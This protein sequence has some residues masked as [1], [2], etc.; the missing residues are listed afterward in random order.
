MADISESK[1]HIFV[2]IENFL[3]K[4][5]LSG[6]LLF[7]AAL[8][9]MALANSPWAESYFNLLHTSVGLAIGERT[10]TMNLGHWVNDGLMALFFLV[11]G[12]EIKRELMVGEL[13]SLQ[14]AAFPIA[15]AAGGMIVPV[16][17]YIAVNLQCGGQ[18]SGFGIPMATDIAFALGF[19][20]LLGDRVPLSL[21][22]F[23]T[24]LA[25][26][27]DLGAIIVIAV[28]YTGSLHL[29]ALGYAAIAL[30]ALIALNRFG[31]KKLWPY[32]ILGVALWLCV[33]E[34]GIHA[35]IAGVLLALTIPVRARI[36]SKK[37]L[38]ICHSEL[39]TFDETEIN[40]KDMVLTSEQQDSLEALEDAYEAVQNPL[41]RLEHFLHP[42]SAFFIM[43]LFALANA[44][45]QI[46]GVG[47]SFFSPVSLGVLAGL[48]LGKPLGIAGATIVLMIL[49]EPG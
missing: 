30:G 44:G 19:L 47:S 14:Q 17:F 36:D 11:I 5:A 25:V 7:G 16:I 12:L 43:P 39:T 18:P 15:G 20:L 33:E 22:V 42:I 48:V 41:V 21:K 37:F 26:F 4:E 35:T 46:S 49:C 3:R 9:A 27:D 1:P 10:I 45:V 2:V 29:A 31:V 32:L 13:S 6:F 40:R 28:F 38:K 8:L 23:L 34:S 24:S